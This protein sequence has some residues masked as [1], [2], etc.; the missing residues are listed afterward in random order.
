MTHADFRRIELTSHQRLELILLVTVAFYQTMSEIASADDKTTMPLDYEMAWTKYPKM[1]DQSHPS[2]RGE[3]IV[4]EKIH[5]ANFSI[6]ISPAGNVEFAKRTGILGN[7]DDFYSIRTSGFL[8]E[9]L[10]PLA[11][12]IK[13]DTEIHIYGE[14]FGG[15]YPHSDIEPIVGM[16]PVQRGIWYSPGLEFIAFDVRTNG[17]FLD[18]DDA[19]ELCEQAGFMFVAP[20]FRG[21]LAECNSFPNRFDSTIP[22]RFGLSPLSE[23]NLAEGVVIRPARE[24]LHGNNRGLF[25][26]KIPEFQED[27]RYQNPNYK[28]SRN[29]GGNRQLFMGKIDLVRMEVMAQ[30]TEQRLAAVLSKIGRVD[31]KD[32]TAC[33]ALLRAF[34]KDIRQ[35]LAED[36]LRFLGE[37]VEMK[38]ELDASCREII[39]KEL[40]RH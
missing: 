30:V 7:A 1:P 9:K 25:K 26:S 20:L 2:V 8:E 39:I 29:G 19:K 21:S 33:K 10:F 12:A 34:K 36:D 17:A 23:P 15:S 5:G 28:S 22:A 4:S 18:H 3:Y 16:K 32:T 31:P 11:R 24:P 13:D 40:N 38:R 27:K 37:S 14:L 35:S 6:L